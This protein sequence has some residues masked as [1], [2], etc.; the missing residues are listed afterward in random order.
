[1]TK[2]L[3][4]AVFAGCLACAAWSNTASADP[5]IY[6]EVDVAPPSIESYP[7]TVYEGRPVYY[8][9]GHWY[10]RRGPRWAY[11]REEPRPLVVYRSSPEYRRYHAPPPPPRRHYEA[12]PARDRRYD[13][14]RS[15]DRRYE[16]RRR[17]DRRRD[18][19]REDRRVDRRDDHHH[20]HD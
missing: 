9:E 5:P 3:V 15:D 16:D 1:M 12:R 10:E 17:D 8:Y 11:Y 19:R 7:H 13:D 6:I 18:N 4:A 20:R 14:R 2:Q